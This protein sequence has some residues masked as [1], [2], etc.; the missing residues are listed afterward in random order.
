MVVVVALAVTLMPSVEVAFTMTTASST[1]WL[2]GMRTVSTTILSS[3]ASRV[4][5]VWDSLPHAL[6]APSMDRMKVSL[7]LPSLTRVML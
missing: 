4:T 5:W 7:P 1:G 2:E 6:R 3:A